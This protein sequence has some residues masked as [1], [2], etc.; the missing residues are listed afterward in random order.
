MRTIRL[1]ACLTL[2]VRLASPAGASPREEA[3]ARLQA[4]EQA[5]AAQAQAAATARRDL[6]ASQAQAARLADQRAQQAAALRGT[7][8]AI[9]ATTAQLAQAE[10]ARA[11]AD[12]DLARHEAQFALLVPIML[13]LQRY[14]AETVL[15]VPAPPAQALEGLLIARGL[16]TTLERE[17]AALRDRQIRA[18]TMRRNAA[19]EAA[20]LASE[21]TTQAVRAAALDHAVVQAQAQVSQA[22]TAGHEAA[23]AIE[24]AAAQAQTLRQAIA[25]MDQ[26]QARAE[27]QAAQE[28]ARAD[29]RR[30]PAEAT[31]ARLRQAAL[32]RPM[33]HPAGRMGQPVAGAVLH[34]YGSAA[35]DGPATGITYSA[36]PQAFVTS[37]CAGRV[38]FAAPFRSYG[39]LLILECGSVDLVLAGLGRIDA[40]AGHATRQGEPLGRM[41][42]APASPTL[43]VELRVHGQPVDPAPFLNAGL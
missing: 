26:A 17:A 8:G 34:A 3:A 42:A 32:A 14:P 43:Y 12:A 37:P 30:R 27:A 13:R 39:K 2:I 33:T 11:Q 21:R 15:A 38:A 16:A 6:A 7:E 23:R 5:R 36:A 35:E 31:A 22:E 25:E 40:A 41:P 24:A 20:R 10:Q 4:A 1:A 29:R 9:V 28:A 18:D 19:A